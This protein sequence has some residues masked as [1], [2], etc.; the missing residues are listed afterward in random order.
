MAGLGMAPGCL[1]T[2][3]LVPNQL[4][5]DPGSLRGSLIGRCMAEQGPVSEPGSGDRTLLLGSGS[6]AQSVSGRYFESL[7]ELAELGLG[8]GKH[9][10]CTNPLDPSRFCL[11]IVF[12]YTRPLPRNQYFVWLFWY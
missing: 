2:W 4:W 9:L 11:L 1:V 5:A 7:K 3:P 10:N 12:F 8:L 6:G